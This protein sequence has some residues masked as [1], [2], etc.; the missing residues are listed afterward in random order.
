M[1]IRERMQGRDQSTVLQYETEIFF[2]VQ[3]SL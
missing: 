2:S 1:G 3:G